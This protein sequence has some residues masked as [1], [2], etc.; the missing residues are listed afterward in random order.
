[1][2]PDPL[3]FERRFLRWLE[4]EGVRTQREEIRLKGSTGSC[5]AYRFTP[6]GSPRYRVLAV[7]GAGNDSLFAWIGFFKRQLHSGA[8]ILTFDLPGHGRHSDALWESDRVGEWIRAA[9]RVAAG[10]RELPMH[11][12]G[13]SLGGSVTLGSLALLGNAITSA[14][15]VVAPREIQFSLGTVLSEFR[16]RILG[17]LLRG[18]QHYGWTGLLPSFGPFK[19]EIYPLRMADPPMR[20]AF[21]Y[22]G[23]LN[24]AIADLI[25]PDTLARVDIP[26]LLVYGELD[27][28]VPREQGAQISRWIPR[29]DLFVA[30]GGTHLSTPLLPATEERIDLWLEE[31]A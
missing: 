22:V 19:R 4:A 12:V 23:V 10:P 24:Q 28:I 27:R 29:S 11:V 17:T 25:V 14:V 8:E 26:V 2:I 3:P 7:H 18:W 1:M 16:P 5:A 15:A 31:H 9:A 13:I 20:S 21:G 6:S 30:P